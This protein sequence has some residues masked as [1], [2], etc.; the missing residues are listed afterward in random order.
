[1]M[2]KFVPCMTKG[3]KNFEFKL[4]ILETTMSPVINNDDKDKGSDY[5]HVRAS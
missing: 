5:S 1:M 4:K 2:G 3:K